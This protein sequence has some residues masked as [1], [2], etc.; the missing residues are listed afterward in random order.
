MDDFFAQ[1][2]AKL[3]PQPVHGHTGRAL[4]CVQSDGDLAV[5]HV[6][7]LAGD[8]RLELFV[9]TRLPGPCARSAQSY[10]RLAEQRLRPPSFEQS[11]GIE[12]VPW[13]ERVAS[14][15]GRDVERQRRRAA[16][17]LGRVCPLVLVHHEVLQRGE[18]E[19][20]ESAALRLRP[21]QHLAVKQTHEESLHQVF[22]VL[23]VI[24]RPSDV[25]VEGVP[26]RL[27][28]RRKRLL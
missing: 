16:A 12:S 27:T 17:S 13:L 21:S 19:R 4:C 5:R 1:Q 8:E 18:Q 23:D 9:E 25:R 10:L 28:Q 20:S 2:I 11:L 22:S 3:P 6:V 14:L 15:G 24:S 26:V 7:I